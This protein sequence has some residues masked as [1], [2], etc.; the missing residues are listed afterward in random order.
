MLWQDILEAKSY[1][2]LL[3]NAFIGKI[4]LARLK[5]L[6]ENVQCVRPIRVV[7]RNLVGC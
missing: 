6:C 1:L 7:Q 2:N 5:S 3:S 4:C